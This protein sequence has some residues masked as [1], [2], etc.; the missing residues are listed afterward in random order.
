[1]EFLVKVLIVLLLVHA[2]AAVYLVLLMKDQ[3]RWPRPEDF[4]MAEI[5]GA[6]VTAGAYIINLFVPMMAPNIL[7]LFS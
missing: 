1:M 5:F 3:H 2:L 6:V 4:Y 7:N